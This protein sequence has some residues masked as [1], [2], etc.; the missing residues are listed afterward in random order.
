MYLETND[1]L[2]RCCDVELREGIDALNLFINA[3]MID[4]QIF[5]IDFAH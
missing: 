1:Y 2:C 4:A 5:V 3:K